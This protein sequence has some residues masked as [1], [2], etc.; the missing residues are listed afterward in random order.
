MALGVTCF[1]QVCSALEV[2]NEV[3]RRIAAYY[4]SFTSSRWL[5]EWD[6]RIPEEA[7]LA[8]ELLEPLARYQTDVP[9]YDPLLVSKVSPAF[10]KAPVAV[11]LMLECL[12]D[13]GRSNLYAGTVDWS[14]RTLEPL[15]RL[16]QCVEAIGLPL[17]ALEPFERSRYAES[18]GWGAP[19]P[20]SF[21]HGAA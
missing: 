10:L 2:E 7:Q 19:Q 13:I 15:R 18:H 4:W 14:E 5:D 9:R 17:P 11:L 6:G 8:L 12:D 16:L 21:F 20:P 3:F 1:E